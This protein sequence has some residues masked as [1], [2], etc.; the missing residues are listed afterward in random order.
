MSVK[1]IV[2]REDRVK[3]TGVLRRQSL[4]SPGLCCVPEHFLLQDPDI[5]I[6]SQYS[7]RNSEEPHE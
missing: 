1:R 6:S 4:L 5:F 7:V 2:M 3:S